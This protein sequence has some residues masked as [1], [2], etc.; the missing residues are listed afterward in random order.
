MI[1][2]LKIFK[3]GDT[4]TIEKRPEKWS[5][6]AGVPEGTIPDGSKGKDHPFI[7]DGL[8]K[9]IIIQYP[10]S[11]SMMYPI[12]GKVAFFVGKVKDLRGR[13]YECILGHSVIPLVL[14]IDGL[15]YGFSMHYIQDHIRVHTPLNLMWL[16]KI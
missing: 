11:R 10:L 4:I 13:G 2:D 6:L 1:D 7:R 8:A 9:K 16:W 15:Y 12:T 3:V 14:E 5:S